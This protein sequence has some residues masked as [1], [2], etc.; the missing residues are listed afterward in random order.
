[1]IQP[2]FFEVIL[3]FCYRSVLELGSGL[4]LTG[5]CMCKCCQLKSYT[6]TD[7]HPQVLF[8]LMK[9]IELNFSLK[10]KKP[11]ILKVELDD[12]SVTKDNKMMR[13]IRRQL[14]VNAE[15]N[16]CSDSAEIMEISYTSSA[17]QEEEE[18]DNE[19]E[20]FEDLNKFSPCSSSWVRND[21]DSLYKL[22]VDD[23]IRLCQF[24]W[25]E[26]IDSL[27]KAIIPDVILAAGKLY[28]GDNYTC[29]RGGI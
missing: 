14:S 23:K 13:S 4:G 6:F 21:K 9:N 26:S 27:S 7:C 3:F 12:K 16:I 5:I 1:M 29:L 24:D 11:E 18:V 15:P 2:I 17:S 8:L 25:E 19:D 22:K 20:I 10:S 28:R